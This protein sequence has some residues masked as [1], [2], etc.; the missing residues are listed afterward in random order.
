MLW[1]VAEGCDHA[2]R[3]SFDVRLRDRELPEDG[4]VGV[5]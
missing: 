4:G 5:V 1:T 2:R 3:D